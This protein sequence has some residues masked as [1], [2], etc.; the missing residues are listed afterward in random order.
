MKKDD[1]LAIVL[2][3]SNFIPSLWFGPA[4]EN[5]GRAASSSQV[6]R[7]DRIAD[8]TG[9]MTDSGEIQSKH[10]FQKILD[11]TAIVL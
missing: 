3:V 11:N 7:T 10:L 2:H 6:A 1:A 5:N 8:M 9:W 4:R